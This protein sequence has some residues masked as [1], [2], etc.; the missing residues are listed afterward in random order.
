MTER[1]WVKFLKSIPFGVDGRPLNWNQ[2]EYISA[3]AAACNHLESV[4]GCP[5]RHG[6]TDLQ[7]LS[8]CYGCAIPKE[9][10]QNPKNPSIMLTFSNYDRL[11]SINFDWDV[12]SQT[13]EKI[14]KSLESA[15]FKYVPFSVFADRKNYDAANVQAEHAAIAKNQQYRGPRPFK[16]RDALWHRFFGYY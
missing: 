7:D 16:K 8:W 14:I 11:T 4:L 3:C 6:P 12:C 9:L 5:L 10:L 15:G 2:E 13:L 1:Q